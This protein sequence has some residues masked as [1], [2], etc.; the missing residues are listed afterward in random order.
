MTSRF[1]FRDPDGFLMESDGRLFRVVRRQRA[2]RIL[3]FLETPSARR[4]RE[5]GKLVETF[6]VGEEREREILENIS[7]AAASY[8][9]GHW[10]VLE[11]ERIPFVSYPCRMVFRDAL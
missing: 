7:S 1:S 6:P 11:H 4:L 10:A 9:R 3:E 8:S 2:P 5:A